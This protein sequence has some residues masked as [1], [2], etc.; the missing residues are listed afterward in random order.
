MNLRLILLLNGIEKINS[1]KILRHF[2]IF[3][4]L[5]YNSNLF[6]AQWIFIIALLYDILV[7][8]RKHINMNMVSE[9]PFVVH[10]AQTRLQHEKGQDD[11]C[12]S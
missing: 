12:E 10:W 11:Y 9:T 5:I 3:I 4:K 2:K 1:L 7:G 6:S 8:W